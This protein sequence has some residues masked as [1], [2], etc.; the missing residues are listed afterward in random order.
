[1]KKA[2]PNPYIW[3]T[4]IV[5]LLAADDS[6]RWAPWFKSHFQYD[7]VEKGDGQLKQW[8][9]D[10]GEMVTKRA[11]RLRADGFTVYLEDQNKFTLRGKT[12]I[13]LAGTPD[14][15]AIKGDDALVVDCKSGK[16]RDK[17]YWQVCI[18]MFVLPI[19]HEACKGL[20]LR[21]EVQYTDG[22]LK[23]HPDEGEEV[24]E[25]IAAQVKESGG[26]TE[27]A[28]VPSRRECKFCNIGP[29]DCPAR[30]DDNA[31]VAT[32]TSDAF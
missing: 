23:I 30:I 24:V 8:K 32:A 5:G 26:A 1:M 16:R 15:V 27:P 3:V 7:K 31:P 18:Y 12:G 4:W 25:R 22:P 10:H 19:T 2:R 11:A 20:R 14:I 17:D 21:G 29:K 13:E 9:A 6:C 28:R